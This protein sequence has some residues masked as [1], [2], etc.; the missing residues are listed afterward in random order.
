MLILLEFNN[1]IN[2]LCLQFN[3]LAMVLDKNVD[4]DIKKKCIKVL[5]F[6]NNNINILLEKRLHY[7]NRFKNDIIEENVK[8]IRE[9]TKEYYDIAKIFKKEI[10][11]LSDKININDSDDIKTIIDKHNSLNVD[12]T[13]LY[14][15]LEDIKNNIITDMQ[16]E[17][18]TTDNKDILIKYILKY[19]KFVKKQE[20]Y[21]YE[22][23]NSL[24][25]L[26]NTIIIL[27]YSDNE[28][29]KT[30]RNKFIDHT[31]QIKQFKFKTDKSIKT[32]IRCLC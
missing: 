21:F 17:I 30:L 5:I 6:L 19:I 4:R 24:L 22:V 11:E 14:N 31:D 26:I 23:N 20:K 27:N 13:I 3:K 2:K 15:N 25:N 29:R 8:I 1:K 7:V 12:Y 9:E 16:N 28:Y 18:R 10:K 32:L